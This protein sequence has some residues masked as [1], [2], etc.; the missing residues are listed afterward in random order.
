VGARPVAVDGLYDDLA[1]VGLEYGPVFQGVVQA[2]SE[3][4]VV[5]A[6]V[7][8]PEDAH[9]DAARFGL[10]PA[11]LDA[12]LHAG[13]LGDLLPAPEPGRPYL[14]F[15]WTGVSL[16]ATGATSLRI[17]VTTRHAD[18][19]TPTSQSHPNATDIN[20][21]AANG[22]TANG[23]AANGTGANGTGANGIHT[24]GAGTNGAGTNGTSTNGVHG[25]AANGTHVNGAAGDGGYVNGAGTNGSSPGG[26][27]AGGG[28]AITL[29]I[30]DGAGVPVAEVEGLTLRPVSTADV[31]GMAG[32]GSLRLLEW[33]VVA[34][35]PVAEVPRWV[36]LGGDDF[37]VSAECYPDLVSLAGLVDP[38][39]L[40]DAV[41]APCPSPAELAELAELGGLGELSEEV[42]A[43]DRTGATPVEPRGRW[44][45]ALVSSYPA[46]LRVVTRAVLALLQ[47]WSACE[48]FGSSRLVVVTRGG[49][50]GVRVR[51]LIWRRR[52]CGVWCVRR[53]PSSRAGSSCWTWMP[54]MCR[55]PR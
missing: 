27:A 42:F 34:V 21:S 8:L 14:P 6:E 29:S 38:A 15:A 55:R 16:H 3:P 2:W 32:R 40:P 30:A 49:V 46:A 43:S 54:G 39:E 11:L 45:E 17:K 22:V 35:D 13:A 24:N 47:D 51:C 7:V 18:A 19:G 44:S 20:G 33:G 48:E 41:L 12:A 25:V 26:A 28:V 53:R 52:R 10:H 36:V 31:G 1:A 5:F 9:A 37:G 4:G 23:V 50:V